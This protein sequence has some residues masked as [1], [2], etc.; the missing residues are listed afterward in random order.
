V[1]VSITRMGV[2]WRGKNQ[3]AVRIAKV[4]QTLYPKPTI[5]LVH[6]KQANESDVISSAAL[7]EDSL[8]FRTA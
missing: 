8:E 4:L 6:G 7:I 2:E 5:P 1:K 3:K